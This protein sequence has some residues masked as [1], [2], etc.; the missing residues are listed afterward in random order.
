MHFLSHKFIKHLYKDGET[1]AK[2]STLGK[3]RRQTG[4]TRQHPECLTMRSNIGLF[5]DRKSMK[6]ED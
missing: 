1:A 4:H 3:S 5:N 6:H 2:S